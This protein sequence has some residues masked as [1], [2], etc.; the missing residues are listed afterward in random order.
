MMSCSSSS[1]FL[2]HHPHHPHHQEEEEEE[3]DS[4]KKKKLCL[5]R[6]RGHVFGR[7]DKT[8]SS[9]QGKDKMTN[10]TDARL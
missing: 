4:N 9:V 2:S 1:C 7:W 6:D 5:F 8:F 10:M 3:N